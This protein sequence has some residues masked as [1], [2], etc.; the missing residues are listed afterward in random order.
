MSNK[1]H[2]LRVLDALSIPYT[3][4]EHPPARS[5]E[6]CAAFDRLHNIPEDVSHCK[7]IF[8]ANRQ[9]TAFYLA[10]MDGDKRFVT[11]DFC[12]ALSIPRVSFAKEEDLFEHMGCYPGSASPLG[13]IFDSQRRITLVC[14]ESLKHKRSLLLHPADNTATVEIRKEDFFDVFLKHTGH[15]P[16]FV[17]IWENSEAN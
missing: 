7:N 12:A 2:I 10:L 1:E 5:M 8:L 15:V 11:K 16:I 3:Y 13:L 17:D 9:N 6:D 4:Y 14:D